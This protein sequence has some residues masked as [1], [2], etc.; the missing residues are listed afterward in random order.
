MRRGLGSTLCDYE[1]WL[2]RVTEPTPRAAVAGANLFVDAV[3]L[4][5]IAALDS[6][7]VPAILLKGP[8]IATWIYEP[9]E[10][11]YSDTDLLVDPDAVARAVELLQEAG[12]TSHA[13]A[14]ELDRPLHETPMRR[15]EDGALV[16]LHSTIPGTQCPPSKVWRVLSAE[17][18]E[19]VLRDRRVEI[20][21]EPARAFHVALHALHHR[22]ESPRAMQDLSRAI[23][24]VDIGVWEHARTLAAPLQS[25][26]ALVAGLRLGPGGEGLVNRLG[27]SDVA[28][29]LEV[30]LRAEGAPPESMSFDWFMT[31]RGLGAKL[32]FVIRK[33]FPPPAVLRERS[34]LA[35]R[36][37]F[38][39]VVAY[40]V[41]PGR[42]ALRAL[43]GGVAWFRIK[44]LSK[45]PA[46]YTPDP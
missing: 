43:R 42:L 32:S 15:D 30:A 6:G 28:P 46:S 44:K 5:A 9:H 3:T 22:G 11:G 35:R 25:T 2:T 1:R 24:L 29:S 33:A 38:G 26:D 39:L 10:R 37:R 18:Q 27:L 40:L 7:G 20:L 19:L 23:A 41:R 21:N 34:M 13:A 8:S 12:F 45:N 4:E 31:R 16:E 14:I 36:G 17:T